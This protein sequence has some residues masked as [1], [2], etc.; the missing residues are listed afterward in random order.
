MG[1]KT[2]Q[3]YITGKKKKRKKIARFLTGERFLSSNILNII[4]LS[5]KFHIQIYS[6]TQLTSTRNW[7]FSKSH[8]FNSLIFNI[9]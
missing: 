4:L 9:I 5:P 6:F 3:N 7:L 8:T 2:T 1:E